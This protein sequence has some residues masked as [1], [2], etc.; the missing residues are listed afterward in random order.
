M[1]TNAVS[2]ADE[3]FAHVKK[4]ICNLQYRPGEILLIQQLATEY[5]SSRTPVKEALIRLVSDNYV[6]MVD[7][8]HFRVAEISE[9][10]VLEI[11]EIRRSLESMVVEG[12]ARVIT[13]EQLAELGALIER[14]RQA[15]KTDDR[16]TVLQC[17]TT[18]HNRLTELYGNEVNRSVLEMLNERIQRTRFLTQSSPHLKMID[19][20]HGKVL[21]ALRSRDGAEAARYMREHLTNVRED[22]RVMIETGGTAVFAKA[23]LFSNIRR[24][25]QNV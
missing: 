23:V 21:E 14:S 25:P 24:T 11:F 5:E 19:G 20:E 7:G 18:F 6:E 22:M 10:E 2:R 15:Q 8:G 9:D 4:K 16:L 3:I 13:D 17:D 12:L 1:S